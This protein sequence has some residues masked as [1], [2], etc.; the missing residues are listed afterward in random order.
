MRSYLFDAHTGTYELFLTAG[1]KYDAYGKRQ[2]IYG[3]LD[4]IGDMIFDGDEY[5]PSPAHDPEGLDAAKDL[6][7]FLTLRPGDTDKEYFADYT[8]DQMA[9]ALSDACE[10]LQM[11]TLED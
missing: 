1:E 9:F 10:E 3:L 4:P 8:P 2:V 5:Y 7:G 11:Y 6:L